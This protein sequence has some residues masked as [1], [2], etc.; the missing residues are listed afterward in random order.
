MGLPTDIKY[1]GNRWS[2]QV[3]HQPNDQLNL[4]KTLNA[5][6]GPFPLIIQVSETSNRAPVHDSPPRPV[7]AENEE[8]KYEIAYRTRKA[9]GKP[10]PI[11]TKLSPQPS[12]LSLAKPEPSHNILFLESTSM[13]EPPK[14][15]AIVG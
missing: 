4:T 12:A 5:G 6:S 9:E 8:R 10:R 15:M 3:T 11:R 13:S 7:W 14:C 2:T 1:Q